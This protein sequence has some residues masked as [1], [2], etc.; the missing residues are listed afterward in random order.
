MVGTAKD[1]VM[2]VAVSTANAGSS[3]A[4]STTA[5]TNAPPSVKTHAVASIV[6]VDHVAKL[7]RA[8]GSPS[9]I[10]ESPATATRTGRMNASTNVCTAISWTT[11]APVMPRNRYWISRDELAPAIAPTATVNAPPTTASNTTTRTTAVRA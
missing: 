10:P 4:R 5:A 8:R 3:L 2:P 9:P 11:A 1:S 7:G 6:T